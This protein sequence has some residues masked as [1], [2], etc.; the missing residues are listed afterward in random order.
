MTANACE[1]TEVTERALIEYAEHAVGIMA[2]AHQMWELCHISSQ[3]YVYI[4]M[5]TVAWFT[6]VAVSGRRT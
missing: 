3:V 4:I 1:C 2:C 5:V 6:N